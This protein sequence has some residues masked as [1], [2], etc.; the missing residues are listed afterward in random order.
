MKPTFQ[1]VDEKSIKINKKVFHLL[2]RVIQL[3]QPLN[4]VI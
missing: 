2:T 3:I 4:D 1:I